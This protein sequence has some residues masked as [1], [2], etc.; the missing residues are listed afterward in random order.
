MQKTHLRF[1][2]VLILSL[3][4]M[5]PVDGAQTVVFRA[6][7]ETPATTNPPAGWSMWGA[8]KYKDP[9]NFTRDTQQVHGGAASFRIHHPAHTEGYIVSAPDAAIQPR[10]GKTYTASFWARSDRAGEAIFGWTAYRQIQP[11]V[12]AP[13]PG[14]FPLA[15]DQQWKRFC[16]TLH[17]G[18]DFFAEDCRYLLL[19]FRATAQAAEERTLWIDDVVVTEQ[20]SQ[21][22]GRL[23]NPARLTYQPLEHRLRSGDQLS[24]TIDADQRLRE[25]HREVGGVS[26]H[27]VA[28]WARLPFD[29]QGRY[30]LPEDLE[31]AIRQMRLPMTRFYALGD[32]PFGLETAIDKA[33]EFLDRIGIDQAATPLEFEIQGATSKLSPEAWARGVRHSLDRGY[34]F[35]HWEVSN[36]PYVGRAGRAFP[37][38]DSY[39]EHF[40][41]VSRAIRSVHAESRIGLAIAHRHPGWGNYLLKQAAGQYDFV[42]GHYYSFPNWQRSSFE[43]VVLSGNYQILD[44]ILQTNALLHLYNP[45]RDVYQYDTEWGLHSAGPQGE[46]ADYVFRNANIWGMMHRAVRL[47]HYLREDLLRGASSWEMFTYQRAPGFGFFAQDA[48]QLRSMNYW[49]YYYFN[50]HAGRWVLAI[51]GTAP[52][53]E[54]TAGGRAYRGPLTPVVATLSGDERQLYLIIA[55]GSSE[56][57]VPARVEL[58]GF[59]PNGVAGVVLSHSDPDASPFLDNREELVCELLVEVRGQELTMLLPPRA[60][61]FVTVQR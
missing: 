47:I 10:T 25:T 39:L 58:R 48:P 45:A 40:L 30:V 50:R 42:V 33:A 36:E 51:E 37:T 46:R 57:S 19:T 23:I 43:D 38:A 17:E 13:S 26:F 32:E 52:Y 61:A 9:A 7:F 34:R 24:F 53:H 18:W 59:V 55:N 29:K 22:D 3:W 4:L 8:Q 16:F 20:P 15:V 28:G 12:D 54:G 56:T 2:S 44:E 21:R 6:D 5:T 60:V 27:R 49:L 1:W 11:F 35:R 41:A 14:F 31:E